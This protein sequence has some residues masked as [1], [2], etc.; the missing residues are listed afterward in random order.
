[1]QPKSAG[2][3][4]GRIFCSFSQKNSKTQSSLNF[5]LAGPP[6][7]A[8]LNF[9]VGP[10]LMSSDFAVGE[11]GGVVAIYGLSRGRAERSQGNQYDLREGS[12]DGSASV[13][14]SQMCRVAIQ[15]ASERD[16]KPPD[17]KILKNY[18]KRPK[19]PTPKITLKKLLKNNSSKILFFCIF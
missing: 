17:P 9:G 6:K 8:N 16:P 10:D 11:G 19:G 1:M 4:F 2:S 18:Q 5:L 15:G 7:S 3:G 12:H 14:P 13:R